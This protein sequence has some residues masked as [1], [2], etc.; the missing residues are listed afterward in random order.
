VTSEP[1]GPAPHGASAPHGAPAPADPAA[2]SELS[3][4]RP[5]TGRGL[6]LRFARALAGLLFLPYAF[7]YTITGVV[8]TF[9]ALGGLVRGQ[10][11]VAVYDIEG[12]PVRT[13]SLG[14][15]GL[16]LLLTAAVVVSTMVMLVINVRILRW[17]Q[18]LLGATIALA[19]A[20]ALAAVVGDL[21]FTAWLLYFGG[22]P[23]VALAAIVE[24]AWPRARPPTP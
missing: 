22:L 6:A 16:G 14:L 2:S 13:W 9:S 5:A 24:L 1:A 11:S 15:L 7:Y 10:D 17:W 23:G 21:S 4:V 18:A 20:S 12:D 8:V 19:A 3:P